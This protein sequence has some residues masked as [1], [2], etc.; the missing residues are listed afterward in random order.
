M[1]FWIDKDDTIFLY[2][3]IK[4]AG[5][6]EDYAVIRQ[7]IREGKVAVND[8]VSLSQRQEIKIG[9]SIRY[10]SIHL[11]IVA[12]SPEER[13]KNSEGTGRIDQQPQQFVHHGITKKWSSKPLQEERKLD[14]KLNDLCVQLHKTCTSKKLTLAL[15]ESCTGGM[16]QSII[17]SLP[18][19][20]DFFQ[21]GVVSYSNSIKEKILHVKNQTLQEY[22]AVSRQT[23]DE[24]AAGVQKLFA[25]DVSGSITG[26]AG[27]TGG[28]AEKPVGL[29]F[30]SVKTKA[31]PV[32][33]KFLFSGNRDK[34][35][36]KTV[37]ELFR[38]ILENI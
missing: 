36:K 22:G 38:L 34:I 23:A 8:Q 6:E 1:K 31:D 18:G 4:A 9:D 17:T 14:N 32:N 37:L 26:I 35:R 3:L 15:A 33:R 2:Q 30:I 7:V 19:A 11:K 29:V 10:K 24:M 12:N 21:G 13:E 28:T 16:A 5:L 27:P 20:S 25:C